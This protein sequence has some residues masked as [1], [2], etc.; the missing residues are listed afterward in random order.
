MKLFTVE[1]YSYGRPNE[2]DPVTI[3]NNAT[4]AGKKLL[5]EHWELHAPADKNFAHFRPAGEDYSKWTDDEIEA[6]LMTYFVTLHKNGD[7]Y[8]PLLEDLELITSLI[9]SVN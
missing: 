6:T 4:E 8:F 3:A 1:D 2:H 5:G 7:L 9:S